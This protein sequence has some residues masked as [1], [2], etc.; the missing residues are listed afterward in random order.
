MKSLHLVALALGVSAVACSG[1]DRVFP[2]ATGTSSGPGGGGSPGPAGT[3]G[4]ATSA[5]GDD[6]V[7]STGQGGSGQGGSGQGGASGQGGEGMGGDGGSPPST[8]DLVVL[9]GALVLRTADSVVVQITVLREG[10]ALEP[11]TITVV[12]LPDGVTADPLEIAADAEQA[13]LTLHGAVDALQGLASTEVVAEAGVLS[14]TS[15]LE[16]LVA[17]APGTPDATFVDDTGTFTRQIGASGTRGRD[18]TLQADGKIVVAGNSAIENGQMFALR[19]DGAG[20]LDTEFNGTGIVGVGVGISG[21]WT[22]TVDADDRVILGG[23]GIADFDGNCRLAMVALLPDGTID[24]EFGDGG[25]VTTAQA[26]GCGSFRG[27]YPTDD[28][29]VGIGNF[30]DG[31]LNFITRVYE[32]TDVLTQTR[33]ASARLSFTGQ[34]P[35]GKLLYGGRDDSNSMFVTRLADPSTPDTTFNASGTAA[36]FFSEGAATAYGSHVDDAG[37]VLLGGTLNDFTTPVV[38]FARFNANGSIDGS[39]GVAGKVV[40]SIGMRAGSASSVAVDSQGRIFFAGY[41]PT[42]PTTPAV[43]RFLPDGTSDATFGTDG[44][45]VVTL[46]LTVAAGNSAAAVYGIA[47]DELDRVILVGEFGDPDAAT[48]FVSRL[49]F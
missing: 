1:P 20:Q 29:V 16:L 27:L 12:G 19:L 32:Y 18:V 30:S 28:S 39:F 7:Q 9:E 5:G 25:S 38:A 8:L 23:F 34:Q 10:P 2:E 22:V 49:W 15:P 14:D 45:G 40:T 6:A 3:G 42:S 11:S 4:N 41:L 44:T 48:L 46:D 26:N 36:V 35:D 43:A 17:G 33:S 21:A 37:R 13:D 31:T 24:D 47:V